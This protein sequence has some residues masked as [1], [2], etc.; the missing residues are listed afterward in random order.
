[1]I[2][3]LQILLILTKYEL[4]NE[5]TQNNEDEGEYE[6]LSE[7]NDETSQDLENPQ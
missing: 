4:R 2:F 1:M 6:E 5:I 3:I 7:S